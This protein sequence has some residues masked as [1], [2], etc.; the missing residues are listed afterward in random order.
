MQIMNSLKIKTN[1]KLSYSSAK[2]IIEH[3]KKHAKKVHVTRHSAMRTNFLF[4]S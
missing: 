4:F 1:A 3:T 2:E